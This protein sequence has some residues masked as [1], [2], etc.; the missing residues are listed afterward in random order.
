M[1]TTSRRVLLALLLLVTPCFVAGSGP[2]RAAR[3]QAGQSVSNT[4]R[5]ADES[6]EPAFLRHL[7]WR[8]IGPYRG[9]RV[10]AVEGHP[11]DAQRFYF[12]SVN[13]GV[14]ETRDAG[15]T[16]QPIFD[17]QPVGSIGALALAPSD[18]STIYVGTGEADMRSDIAQGDG[19]FK[20]MDAGQTWQP[21]GLAQSQQIARI[22][23]DPR[24]ARVVFVAA[25]GHPYAPNAE[26]GVFRS[27]DGGA[28]W[29]KVLGPDADTG[30]VDVVFEP[31]NPRVL[32]AALWQTRRTPWS[33]YPPSSGPGSAL[34]TSTDGG[35][36]WTRLTAGLPATHGRAGFAIAP[37]EPAR[38][39]AVVDASTGG[40]VYRSD[41]RGAHWRLVSGDTRVWQRGWY[42]GRLTVDP[43]NPNR[44]YALNTI[45]LRSDEGGASWIPLKGDPTGDDFHEL[46]ID[47]RDPARQILGTDQGAII[48]MNGGATWS[49]W[50]NQPTGQFYHLATDARFPYMVYGAQQDSGAAGVP[51]RSGGVDGINLTHFREI[52][53]G[54]ESDTVA[55]DP[56]DPDVIYGGRVDRLDLRTGQ[57]RA[58]TPTLA[59]PDLHRTTWTLPLTFSRRDPRVLYFSH[60]HVYRTD[61]GGN[62]WAQISP[63]LTR[64]DPG[65][66]PTLDPV[67]AAVRAQ[68]GPR[69]GVVYTLAPSRVADDDLWA[70]TDDGL[71]WRTRD[72]GSHW[73]NITPS[74]LTPWSKVGAI[75]PSH[76]DASTA[77]IAIDR[78]RLDDFR[79][80]IYRTTDGGRTWVLIVAGIAATHAVNVVRE[81]P[82][83]KGLLYAG[84][85]RGVYVSLDDG[86]SWAALQLDL[87]RTSVR[88]IEV[89]GADVVIATHGRGFWILD[90]VSVL[91]QLGATGEI[92]RPRLFVPATAVRVRTQGF[93]GTPFPQDEP[94]GEN[95]PPGA[96]IDYAL[97]SAAQEVTLTVTDGAGV[98]ARR[99]SSA[100]RARPP[101]L[102]RLTSAPEWVPR[103]PTLSAAAG[104]HRLVWPLRYAPRVTGRRGIPEDGVWAPPGR[105]TIALT[106]DGEKLTAAL[107]VG[108]DPRVSLPA[109]A[110]A[111]QFVL[112]REVEEA[113]AQVATMT[114]RA[115][116]LQRAVFERRRQAGAPIASALDA[117]AARAAAVSGVP[118][119]ASAEAVYG[120]APPSTDTLRFVETMLAS[121]AEAV[122]GADAAPSVDARDGLSKARALFA[123]TAA[124]WETLV[125]KDL[126]VLN[127]T[128]TAAGSPALPLP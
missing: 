28:T 86:A 105:Y 65:V 35:D 74:A 31:G 87:P 64:E 114:A 33:V 47:P 2:A 48:T 11:S 22:I 44:V 93:S 101:D 104:F 79:P 111:E 75:E 59:Y 8:S 81:D 20:S 69:Q 12:G 18:P 24:D 95:P 103:S 53:A 10:L 37:S 78:H 16:W 83:T 67:T 5:S 97:P 7:H 52:T 41:D 60:Q 126:G 76:Y 96:V 9:G 19:L 91:R 110:Y 23:V 109:S 121:I 38:V 113:R 63:D 122:D 119:G 39:Y 90:D 29:A 125:Q 49:S 77:Y 106:V 117:F 116:S 51:S 46:W 124:R 57:T 61:D 73:E 34:F 43:R 82:V 89:K 15:R 115:A 108:P 112:A 102:S 1:S 26:R 70:G 56:S 94:R 25:L 66:P 99:Y 118:A 88:D 14:W 98:E 62:H 3:L 92:D 17:G 85:E 80:Y 84:T 71:V 40:G 123:A 30:A 55:P 58:V 72:E 21:A 36:R 100:D 128:L 54:G 50:H 45:V 4:P 68:A 13:G 32:Y 27:R 107:E 120:Q 6:K 42:F 127:G